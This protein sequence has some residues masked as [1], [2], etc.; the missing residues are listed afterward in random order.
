MIVQNRDSYCQ[1]QQRIVEN[2]KAFAEALQQQGFD[3]EYNGTEN[4]LVLL[5]LKNFRN[6][7]NFR[8]DGETASRLLENIG[9]IVNKVSL[10]ITLYFALLFH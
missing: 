10:T 4:H 8:I 1:L 6:R 9:I 3:L 2:S 5:D 7:S